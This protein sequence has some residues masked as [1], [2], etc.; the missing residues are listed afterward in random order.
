MHSIW[1]NDLRARRVRLGNGLVDPETTLTDDGSARMET[2]LRAREVA[3]AVDSLPEEQQSALFLVYVEG[4]SYREAA[5]ILAIPLGTVMSRLSRARLS[6][7][8]R[9]E[10]PAAPKGQA[11]RSLPR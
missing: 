4:H 3:E 8:N 5:D 1:K 9:V 7:A 6:L 11:L 10:R 2:R